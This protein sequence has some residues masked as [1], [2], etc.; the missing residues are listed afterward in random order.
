MSRAYTP[1]SDTLLSLASNTSLVLA[2]DQALP[3]LKKEQR[4]GSLVA[5]SGVVRTSPTS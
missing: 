2:E 3:G 5:K 1:H 4:N